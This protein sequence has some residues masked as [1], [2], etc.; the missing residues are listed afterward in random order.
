MTN[1]IDR[2]ALRYPTARTP[3][4]PSEA[5]RRNYPLSTQGFGEVAATRRRGYGG[6]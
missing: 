2:P 1:Y 3:S 6:M 5:G 4:A